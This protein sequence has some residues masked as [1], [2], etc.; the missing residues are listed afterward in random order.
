MIVYS[1]TEIRQEYTTK[2][3][4]HRI[5]GI[6][7]GAEDTDDVVG[8]LHHRGTEAHA[9]TLQDGG[10]EVGERDTG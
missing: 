8:Q 7:G 1:D 10:N 9:E 3:T 2:V 5:T 4:L 6:L